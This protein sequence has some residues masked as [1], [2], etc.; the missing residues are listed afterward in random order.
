MTA[1]YPSL[2][3]YTGFTVDL[4]QTAADL[5]TGLVGNRPE[6]HKQKK[7]TF[8]PNH[9]TWH[10]KCPLAGQFPWFGGGAGVLTFKTKEERGLI[11]VSTSRIRID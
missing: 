6:Q 3:S 4:V 8:I 5:A 11:D 7:N 1:D 10:I 2:C 9:L